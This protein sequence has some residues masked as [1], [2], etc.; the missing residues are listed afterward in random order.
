MRARY[1]DEGIGCAWDAK[2]RQPEGGCQRLVQVDPRYLLKGDSLQ[3]CDE[4]IQGGG[5]AELSSQGG[6]GSCLGG[7][8]G[9]GN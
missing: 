1:L 3:L 9:E 6:P 7:F 2:G 8:D 5:G 4:C